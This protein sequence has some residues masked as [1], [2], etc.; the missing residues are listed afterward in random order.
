MGGTDILSP[1][2]DILQCKPNIAASGGGGLARSQQQRDIE[3]PVVRR[4]IFLMT[5][6][7]V[8]TGE[9]IHLIRSSRRRNGIGNGILFLLSLLFGCI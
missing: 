1:L 4:S 2:A 9:R 5:D 6:G 7:Q 8:S 3:L